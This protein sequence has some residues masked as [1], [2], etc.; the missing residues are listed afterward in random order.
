[1]RLARLYAPQQSHLVEIRLAPR[2][3][4]CW[5]SELA[6]AWLDDMAR[7]LGHSAKEQSLQL[8]A[9]AITPKRL[10]LL[11]TP[12]NQ[13]ALSRVV[14][15]IGRRMSATH[16]LGKVFLGRYRSALIEPRRWVL[17]AQVWVERS[18]VSDG[19]TSDALSWA[20]SSARAH[21]GM[22]IARSDWSVGLTDHEDYWACG[23]TPFDRQATYR[24]MLVAEMASGTVQ[25]IEAA[26]QGQ[27][28]L[29]S[30]A[31]VD[32][33]TKIA[34]RAVSPRPRGRPTKTVILPLE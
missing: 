9:W 24:A 7:W 34:S 29:G 33:L 31:Y 19:L 21:T 1:M 23:N 25:Q 4:E 32:Q 26:V 22:P 13:Q 16:K 15:A 28:A 2:L 11:A 3:F 8:H 14:Q 10:R 18:P 5:P 17:L 20:W 27:W 12:P 30:A 6:N